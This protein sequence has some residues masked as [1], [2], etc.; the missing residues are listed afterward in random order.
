[1]KLELTARFKVGINKKQ[2]TVKLVANIEATNGCIDYNETE[3]EKRI[4]E[5][6]CIVNMF[7]LEDITRDHIKNLRI[8]I[9]KKDIDKA[10]RMQEL[11]K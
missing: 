7:N 1:M 10:K 8:E 11:S 4:R 2:E 5:I 6:W 9:S 3:L